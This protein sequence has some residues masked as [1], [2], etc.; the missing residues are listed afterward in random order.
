[1]QTFDLSMIDPNPYQTRMREDPVHIKNLAI[2]IAEQGLMQIPSGRLVNDRVQLAFG[3]SRFAAYQFLTETGNAG[4]DQMPVNILNLDDQQMFEMA[5]RENSDRKDIS[6]VEEAKAMAVY[7]SQFGKTSKEVGSLF[8]I[9]E[10]A[11]RNKLRLLHLPPTVQAKIVNG[12]LNESAARKLLVVS[13]MVKGEKLDAVA[14]K[15]A[16]NL[17]VS[18]AEHVISET[19][20]NNGVVM[21][22]R[23]RDGEPMAGYHLW[24]LDWVV[25]GKEMEPL[26]FGNFYK[27]Y[28]GALNKQDAKR[29]FDKANSLYYGVDTVKDE[30]TKDIVSHYKNPPTCLACPFY[31]K[32]NKTHYC[33]MKLC[34]AGKKFAWQQKRANEVSKELGIPRFDYSSGIELRY[35]RELSGWKSE[36]KELFDK[37]DKNLR[38]LV[39]QNSYNNLVPTDYLTVIDISQESQ[40][41]MYQQK[42]EEKERNS[43]EGRAKEERES[44][45][46]R[47]R[48]KASEEFIENVA[49]D[50]FI[51]A[52]DFSKFSQPALD[53]FVKGYQYVENPT[54]QTVSRLYVERMLGNYPNLFEIPFTKGPIEVAKRI[55]FVA[56][57]QFGLNVRPDL[58]EVA[59]HYS[60]KDQRPEWE[61]FMADLQQDQAVEEE[62]EPDP[63]YVDF[64]E[65][66]ENEE[67]YS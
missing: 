47:E 12:E 52:F 22:E 14:E 48:I 4:F 29:E 59:W 7:S 55:N 49:V 27:Q 46:K 16:D 23:W 62:M 21:W 25:D 18:D 39:K 66:Y 53:F 5:V 44:Q 42:Q 24:P 56:E 51:P 65:T 58:M 36:D 30:T 63:E 38:L 9:S 6:P 26:S 19:L 31:T 60:P 43:A 41:L 54:A 50:I 2:S 40:N 45:A 61:D 13:N 28:N 15:L 20:K 64:D 10:S 67:D 33:G 3:H 8:R 32:F 1:M 57:N 17:S 35:C 34:Y 37:R 11:V